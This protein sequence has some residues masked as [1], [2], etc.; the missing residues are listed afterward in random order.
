MDGK[1]IHTSDQAEVLHPK[2]NQYYLKDLIVKAE[3][4]L[5]S[6]HRGRIEPGG[7]IFPHTHDVEAET[8]YILSGDAE[9]TMG[10]DT[11]VF[12][13][14]N[15]GFAPPGVLHGLRNT[16]SSPVELLAIFTPPLK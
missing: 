8:F 13:A 5:L 6:V 12:R 4:G 15:C 14:G 1:T 7:E 2:H 9:C 10:S 16:G 3:A 11:L